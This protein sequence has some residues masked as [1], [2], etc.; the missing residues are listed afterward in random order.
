[1]INFE[2]NGDGCFVDEARLEKRSTSLPSH[3]CCAPMRTYNIWRDARCNSFSANVFSVTGLRREDKLWKWLLYWRGRA[4][5][6]KH[7]LPNSW[8]FRSDVN[9][10]E[11]ANYAS[12]FGEYYGYHWLEIQRQICMAAS[13]A[14][15]SLERMGRCQLCPFFRKMFSVITERYKESST[16]GGF[17][18]V[19]IGC[20]CLDYRWSFST[21]FLRVLHHPRIQDL[22]QDLQFWKICSFVRWLRLRRRRPSPPPS[23][24]SSSDEDLG[25][26]LLL[27]PWL[28]VYRV[29]T[30]ARTGQYNI[31]VPEPGEIIEGKARCWW[32]R[33]RGR[34]IPV[35]FE[36]WSSFLAGASE[37]KRPGRVSM[38]FKRSKTL[39]PSVFA[40]PL[41]ERDPMKYRTRLLRLG[42]FSISDFYT[43]VPLDGNKMRV[44]LCRRS[45]IRSVTAR[46]LSILASVRCSLK[47]RRLIDG[48]IPAVFEAPFQQPKARV[49]TPRL[50]DVFTAPHLEVC[51]SS[52]LALHRQGE[53]RRHHWFRSFSCGQ[54]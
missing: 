27:V 16:M 53:T 32:R 41:A 47:A 7:K 51:V 49:S 8:L 46:A 26:R 45:L 2:T 33:G 22:A 34:G 31:C 19:A 1:M 6:E 42:N 17:I 43:A 20:K 54:V 21:T 25:Q 14:K 48:G 4:R 5:E 24:N 29:G 23:S 11:D 38:A 39:E 50:I 13:R 36:G 15:P 30:A 35:G 40:V 10:W 52:H 9:I 28:C 18:F 3:H 37:G 12:F 44:G